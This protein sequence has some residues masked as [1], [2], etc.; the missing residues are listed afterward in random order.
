MNP[1]LTHV[2]KFMKKHPD[3]S[4]K[5]ALQAAKKTYKPMK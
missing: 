4:Y 3:M 5:Q 1:W 2:K